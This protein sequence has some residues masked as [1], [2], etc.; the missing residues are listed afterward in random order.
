M[1]KVELWAMLPAGAVA[2]EPFYATTIT[3]HWHY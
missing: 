1:Y 2:T 3:E